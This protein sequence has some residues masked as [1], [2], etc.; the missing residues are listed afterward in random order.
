MAAQIRN[1]GPPFSE[2]QLRQ[3]EQRLGLILPTD[4]SSFLL[5]SN[6]GEPSPGWFRYGD[7]DGDFAEVTQFW[8]AETMESETQAL[9]HN[10]E[11]PDCYVSI[12]A[13]SE[14]DA[15]MISVSPRDHGV[16]F[17]NGNSDYFLPSEFTRVAD[18]F[19]ALL[20]RLDYVEATKPWMMLIDNN[21]LDGLRRWLDA[22]GNAQAKEDI[23]IGFSALEWAQSL[24]RHDMVAL[25]MSRGAQPRKPWWRFWA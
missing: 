5:A 12:G 7:D 16:V 17:W 23:L 25:L 3:V 24:E 13:V 20:P 14:E 11:V 2:Q 1:P 4:Y 8:S 18:S 6:G 9:R 19:A 21:D 15:L 10:Y 22:G